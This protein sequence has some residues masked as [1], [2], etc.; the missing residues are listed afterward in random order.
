MFHT[1]VMVA[2]R[3]MARHKLYS[4]INIGG[5][6]V[7]LA[8]ALLILSFVRF[9]TSFDDWIP[10]AERVHRLETV[11][12][13]EGRGTIEFAIAISPYREHMVKDFPDQ[14]EA[15]TRIG[16]QE[17]T[18]RVGEARFNEQM[19]LV[20]EE[21]FDVLGLEV[22]AGDG[23]AALQD[24]SAL[25][26][27]EA[28][29][30]KYFGDGDPIGQTVSVDD[31]ADYTV[32]AV[33][34]DIPA[35]SHLAF[36]PITLLTREKLNNPGALDAWGG[37]TQFIYVKLKPGIS[38]P[39]FEALLPASFR[40]AAPT[41]VPGLPNFV[42]AD[43]TEI[44][45]INVADAYL[46]SDRRE[47]QRP[48]GD[49][50]MVNAFSIIAALVLVIAVINYTNLAT[51]RATNRAR[52]VALRKT[53]GGARRELILQFIGESVV[54]SMLSAMLAYLIAFGG[55]G[56]FN[57]LLSRELTLSLLN[58]P[59]VMPGLPLLALGI[60][61]LGGIYPAFVLSS[62]KPAEVL[63]ANQPS[64]AASSAFRTVLVVIQFAISAALIYSTAVVFEQTR[65][66][67]NMDL[68]YNKDGM[69]VL[70]GLNLPQVADSA[71]AIKEEVK[72][73]PQVLNAA[74]SSSAP[75]LSGSPNNI[76][77]MPE[78]T[79]EEGLVIE[80]IVV[81]FDYFDTY[82]MELVAGRLF[83]PDLRSDLLSTP[84][85]E[86]VQAERGVIVN[87]SSLSLMG[88]SSPEESLGKHFVANAQNGRARFNIVGV[89][90]DSFFHS[91]HT[92]LTPM[93]FVVAE[94]GLS[95]LTVHVKPGDMTAVTEAVTAIWQRFAP[96]V[97]IRQSFIDQNFADKYAGEEQRGNILL[98]LAGLAVLV[99]AL[100]LFG[101]SAFVAERRTR[102]IGIR[103]VMGAEASAIVF[104]MLKDFSIP[105][106]IAL[107]IG[108][109]LSWYAMNEY[110]LNS[111]FY[112]A[113]IGFGL[114]ALAAALAM[115]IAW[116][117]VLTH[118]LKAAM[119][120]PIH[121]LRYQ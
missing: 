120:S 102:E 39:E 91:I 64:A 12:T 71:E 104:L 14:L 35:N 69:M 97:P 88:F 11:F 50:F 38:G 101:L 28:L 92:A 79:G 54:F 43:V 36:G 61:V 45:V 57:D 59:L 49:R 110:W 70:A 4:L 24:S 32:R 87:K 98:G 111:F 99:A 42:M 25:I 113:E 106:V 9:E 100:G 47:S 37:V 21:F 93:M 63:N 72:R 34:R 80:Q 26:L 65:F 52:E 95:T 77:Q 121:A 40:R 62:F 119:T 7:S 27:T 55:L 78:S 51:A 112:R 89:V 114:I 116:I 22:V 109:P 56:T 20:D 10:D 73:L 17:A 48:P 84:E 46:T 58:N 33:I 23:R 81:D 3:V 30:Q 6:A 90:N 19:S 53:L 107:A 41:V 83:S 67:R 44:K 15:S 16:R 66:A 85:E 2:L 108:L 76:V 115:A 118:T 82:G 29:A 86:G 74:R 13:I 103:K 5:L 1:Y 68:G 60:G 31:S 96:E 105:V 75:P 117:T 8:A 94:N 18:L